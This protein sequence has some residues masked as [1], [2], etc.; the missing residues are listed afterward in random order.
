MIITFT[1]LSSNHS[2]KSYL[3]RL[4]MFCTPKFQL[5]QS[6]CDVNICKKW[7]LTYSVNCSCGKLLTN[8]ISKAAWKEIQG[9]MMQCFLPLKDTLAFPLTTLHSPLPLNHPFRT[10]A[11]RSMPHSVIPQYPWKYNGHRQLISWKS[12]KH[13][14][15]ELACAYTSHTTLS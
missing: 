12:L 3:Q 6:L 11:P 4:E 13:P 14:K 8:C 5:T 7:L 15:S 10:L 1:V 2:S 9:Y